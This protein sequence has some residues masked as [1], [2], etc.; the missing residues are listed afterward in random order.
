MNVRDVGGQVTCNERCLGCLSNA[1]VPTDRK[2]ATPD[3]DR[4]CP[5]QGRYRLF[6]RPQEV[7]EGAV[8]SEHTMAGPVPRFG[9]GDSRRDE[10]E[11]GPLYAGIGQVKQYPL[12]MRIGN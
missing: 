5:R 1:V 11:W 6:D 8:D 12:D 3:A 9:S 4:E 2:L 10:V 7:L